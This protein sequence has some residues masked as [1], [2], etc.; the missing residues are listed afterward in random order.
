MS[1]VKG[2]LVGYPGNVTASPGFS[3]FTLNQSTDSVVYLFR[4]PADDTITHI[5]FFSPARTGTATTW[6]AAI[7]G[8]DTLGVED[9]VI[10]G[11]GSPASVTFTNSSVVTGHNKMA[12]AN[13]L[14]VVRGEKLALAI[15]Y[16]SGTTPS[17]GVND[18]GIYTSAG[19]EVNTNMPFVTTVD[20]SVRTRAGGNSSPFAFYSATTVYGYPIDAN[21]NLIFNSGSSPAIRGAKFNL[22][23]NNSGSTYKVKACQ[24][25]E[26]PNTAVNAFDVRIYDGTTI[27]QDVQ[28]DGGA[29][30]SSSNRIR[31]IPFDS[32]ALAT[33]NFNQDYRIAFEPLSANNLVIRGFSVPVSSDWEAYRHGENFTLTTLSGGTWTDTATTRPFV[34]LEIDD[35]TN[36][37]GS[38]TYIF[39]CEA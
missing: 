23:A 33:L 13:S 4:A 11:G 20:N 35:I 18:L 10:K 16:D 1:A 28:V 37:T 3:T 14:S 8:H 22:P 15:S 36:P 21:Q 19:W 30:A 17:N 2:Q 5:S 31:I 25:F 32:D 27:V 7:Q 29:A 9:G 38:T 6:K 24:F 12:L 34:A 39:N 26:A